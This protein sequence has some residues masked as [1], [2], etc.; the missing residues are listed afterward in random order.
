MA[1]PLSETNLKKQ[2]D[3]FLAKYNPEISSLARNALAKMRKRLPGSLE[4][5]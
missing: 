1:K 2:L 4:M 5:V 3:S